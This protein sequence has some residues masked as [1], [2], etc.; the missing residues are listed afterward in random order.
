MYLYDQL[1][2]QALLAALKGEKVGWDDEILSSDWT[3]L[4]S[5]AQN[6]HVLTMIYDA[7]CKCPAFLRLDDAMRSNLRRMSMIQTTQ[8]VVKTSAFFDLMEQLSQAGYEPLVVK[9]IIC[10]SLYPQPDYRISNDEDLLISPRQFEQCCSC[11]DGCGLHRFLP[12]NKGSGAHEVSFV[13][14]D[15]PLYIELHQYLFSPDSEAYGE[16]N[17]YF[18]HVYEHRICKEIDGN[19]VYTLDHTDHLFYL[20]CHAFKHFLHSGFGIRQICD[21]VMFAD[22]YGSQ[23]DWS[24]IMRQC[25]E[26]RAVG[27]CR[28]IFAIGAKYFEFDYDRACYPIDWQGEIDENP[29]L[30]DLLSGGVYGKS[31]MSRV[32]SSGFTLNAVAASKKGKKARRSVLPVL[33]P[34]RASLEDRYGY[35]SKHPYMLPIAWAERIFSYAKE[36]HQTQDNDA[37][38]S[39]QIGSERIELLR[40]YG[41]ID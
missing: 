6:H 38:G 28:G 16:W 41:V 5:Q 39:L 15:S 37:A 30:E 1:F 8:Q 23:V 2:L 29:M 7:V 20:I 12:E 14:T 3:A 25:Q 27:F 26:I 4:F 10:R 18:E 22:T 13:G 11:L 35:L 34:S 17:R 36:T 33:F 31:S 19:K 40:F 24:K 32:H 21:I 9:G